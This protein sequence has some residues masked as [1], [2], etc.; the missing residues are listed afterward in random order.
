MSKKIIIIG[1]GAHAKVVLEAV[2]LQGLY[3]VQGFCADKMSVGEDIFEDYK[4]LGDAML[5]NFQ[6]DSNTYF[7]VAIGDNKARKYFFENASKK[8]TPAIIIHPKASISLSSVIGEG[9]IILSN[10]CINSSVILG[11]N[12]IVNIGVLIDHDCKVGS[13]VHL[14]VGTVVGSNSNI[15]DNQTTKI[16]DVI[17]PDSKK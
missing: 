10:A 3:T 11:K 6:I 7:I 8:C 12:T 2:K 1:A 13:H 17:S 9:S 4:I 15:K 14:S 5:S 16:G